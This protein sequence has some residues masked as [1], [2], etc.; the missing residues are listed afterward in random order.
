VT[1]PVTLT[2]V[3]DADA[4]LLLD[5][6]LLACH[7]YVG[8]ATLPATATMQLRFGDA[9]RLVVMVDIPGH[10]PMVYDEPLTPDVDGLALVDA[11]S[12]AI[13]AGLNRLPHAT[14]TALV[15]HL[16]AQTGVL[17]LDVDPTLGRADVSVE[18][19]R[20][21]HLFSLRSGRAN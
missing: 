19:A 8:M 7:P 1:S 9:V 18:G 17:V 2:T 5:A 13:V 21:V 20:T 16:D 11:A 6:L 10:D 4:G 12:E 3:A 15:R 14:R